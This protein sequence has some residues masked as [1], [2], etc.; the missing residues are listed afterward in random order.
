MCVCDY[1]LYIYDY[2]YVYIY[3][4]LNRDTKN[5]FGGFRGHNSRAK[6][7]CH[8]MAGWDLQLVVAIDAAP[9]AE[10]QS[11]WLSAGAE[12]DLLSLAMIHGLLQ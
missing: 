12:L 9:R 1:I 4:D 6:K 2:M 5:L 8:P 11:L 7:S 10:A 3:M